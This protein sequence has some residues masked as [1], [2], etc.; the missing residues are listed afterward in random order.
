M[1]H[2]DSKGW[3]W[4]VSAP[5]LFHRLGGVTALLVATS[6]WGGAS[7]AADSLTKVTSP[8]ELKTEAQLTAGC[9]ST[10]WG[11]PEGFEDQVGV[12][13][14]IEASPGNF[15]VVVP[16]ADYQ[17]GSGI[18]LKGSDPNVDLLVIDLSEGIHRYGLGDSG[19]ISF[20]FACLDGDRDGEHCNENDD[21]TGGGTCEREIVPV[22]PRRFACLG[23]DRA[24]RVC[25][26]DADCTGA[27]A[28]CEREAVPV[29]R[30][31]FTCSGG[32]RDGEVCDEDADCTGEGTCSS[33]RIVAVLPRLFTCSGGDDDGEV[34][35]DDED[36]AGAGVCDRDAPVLSTL[37][38]DSAYAATISRSTECI[39]FQLPLS[40]STCNAVGMYISSFDG[41]DVTLTAHGEDGIAIGARTFSTRLDDFI[42]VVGKE[43]PPIRF[44]QLRS[45]ETFAFDG[46]EY[47]EGT[48]VEAIAPVACPEPS[49]A[50]LALSALVALATLSRSR[51]SSTTTARAGSRPRR[52]ASPSI[53]GIP[54]SS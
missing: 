47:P 11:D 10:H 20:F 19:D 21:C 54:R 18:I 25:S 23:G 27:G 37:P 13:G 24:G 6:G 32:D 43:A 39:T 52:R 40:S 34:C 44:I 29:L 17:F 28:S 16:D 2:R 26:E 1:K 4:R 48:D 8:S 31:R 41:A 51:R 42:G 3:P 38:A 50:A 45:E 7:E 15:A 12:V 33:S 5:R 30:E 9:N 22:L 14:K 49:S 35:T 46:I 36:C 53:P